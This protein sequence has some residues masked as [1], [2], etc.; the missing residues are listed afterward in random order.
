MQYADGEGQCTFLCSY[1]ILYSRDVE[2]T[3]DQLDL[4]FWL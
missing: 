3:A 2:N 4:D 1:D